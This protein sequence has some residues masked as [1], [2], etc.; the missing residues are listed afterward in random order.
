MKEE[1]FPE[2][3]AT[4][5]V[6]QSKKQ[7]GQGPLASSTYRARSVGHARL[8]LLKG[9]QADSGGYSLRL[10]LWSSSSRHSEQF[11]LL[12]QRPDSVRR[13]RRCLIDD[14]S[15][16]FV[17]VDLSR[18]R[19]ELVVRDAV[20]V[21]GSTDRYFGIKDH[22]PGNADRRATK[23]VNHSV[24]YTATATVFEPKAMKGLQKGKRRLVL[25][26][27]REL[28]AR[29]INH[30]NLLIVNAKICGSC[31]YNKRRGHCELTEDE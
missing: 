5:F 26:Q 28:H 22:M 15:L 18:I 11:V 9:P 1:A 25:V 7:E 3:N 8:P 31:S 19:M 2:C 13:S 23:V 12:Q 27:A 30:A 14:E 10:R 29:W 4:R 21:K 20:H 16:Q 24:L 6:R 17:L